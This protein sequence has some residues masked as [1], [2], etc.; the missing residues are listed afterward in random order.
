M[1]KLEIYVNVHVIA[2]DKDKNTVSV[3]LKQN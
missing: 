2:N 1:N 3:S